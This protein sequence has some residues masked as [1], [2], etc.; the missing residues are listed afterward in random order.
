VQAHDV[1][2]EEVVEAI[3]ADMIL[4]HLGY[5]AAG[6]RGEEFRRDRGSNDIMENLGGLAAELYLGA[7]FER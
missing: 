1:I 5:L 7:P 6:G 4:G 2:E 3:R